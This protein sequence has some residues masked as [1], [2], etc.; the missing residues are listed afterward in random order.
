MFFCF[1]FKMKNQIHLNIYLVKLVTIS[2]Y[3]ITI[4][5]IKESD[6]FNEQTPNFHKY[7]FA[8]SNSMKNK[9]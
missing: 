8:Y 9:H 1:N 2:P 3:A 4:N 5:S 6:S 7:T